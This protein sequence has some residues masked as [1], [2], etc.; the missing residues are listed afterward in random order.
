MQSRIHPGFQKSL[1]RRFITIWIAAALSISGGLLLHRQGYPLL[2]WVLSGLFGI[3][4][5][6]GLLYLS[7]R[8][9]HVKC[10]ECGGKTRTRKDATRTQWVA[11]CEQ[12]QIEWDL[13]TG[14]GGD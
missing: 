4:V 6:G 5:L 13:Q 7:W 11:Q 2:G 14:A 12:C 3:L 10:L 9:H 8:L 1:Q